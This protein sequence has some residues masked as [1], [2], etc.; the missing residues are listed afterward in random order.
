[1]TTLRKTAILLV[2]VH[3]AAAFVELTRSYYNGFLTTYGMDGWLAHTPIGAHFDLESTASGAHD[4][5]LKGIE[6]VPGFLRFL[7]DLGDTVNSLASVNY[8]FL[9]EISAAN[10]LFILVLALRLFSIGV[11]F[12]AAAALVQTVMGSGLLSSKVGLVMLFGSVGILAVL[13]IFF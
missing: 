6:T 3:I 2:I 4:V 5:G 9:S 1:M 8:D 7:F 13:G 10:F 11:W 12:A